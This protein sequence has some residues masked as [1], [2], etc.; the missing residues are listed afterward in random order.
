MIISMVFNVN[1][2]PDNITFSLWSKCV[3]NT[4]HGSIVCETCYYYYYAHEQFR[5]EHNIFKYCQI[6]MMVRDD[7]IAVLLLSVNFYVDLLD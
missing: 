5:R 3:K 7:C 4:Y 1:A 6:I 2:I